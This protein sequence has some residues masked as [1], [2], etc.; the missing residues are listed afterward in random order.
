[1]IMRARRYAPTVRSAAVAIL[2]AAGAVVLVLALGRTRA[3]ADWFF[4][5]L[6][7]IWLW[8]LYFSAG[9]VALGHALVRR[10]TP[11]PARSTLE[12]LAL[13]FPLG[14]AGF[15]LGMYV[16]GFLRIFG[17]AFAVALPALMIATGWRDARRALAESP[18]P[19]PRPLSASAALISVFGLAALGVL[20]LG[21]MSPDAL[22]YDSVWNHLV[23]AQDYAREG[24]IV[25]F[26]G[27]W[28]KNLPH[29]GS[30][31]NAWAF[32]VPGLPLPALHWMMALHLEFTVTLWTIVGVAAGARWIA[33]REARG[34]WAMFFLFPGVFVY[35]SNMGAASDHYLAVFT[36]ATFLLASRSLERFDRRSC[37][38]WGLVT[39]AAFLT[40]VHALYIGAPLAFA[41][42]VRAAALT[43]RRAAGDLQA[44][45][46]LEIAQGLG[47]A[48][49][50]TVFVMSPHLVG[51]LV[52]FKNPVY[53]LLQNVF[54]ASTPAVK[55]AALQMDNLFVDWRWHPPHALGARAWAALKLV[56][57]FS[58]EPHYSFIENL[59]M[60]G[61]LFTLGLALLPLIPPRAGRLWWGSAV[62]LGA[63]FTWAF[64]FWVDRNLQIFMPLL[65]A[66]TAAVVIRA[67]ELGRL[68][69]VGLAL[70][71]TVQLAWAV[72]LY[73]S[74]RDRITGAVSLLS[75]AVRGGA[76]TH[77]RTYRQ[78]YIALGESLPKNAVVML[79]N[80]HGMLGIDR[81]VL[82]DWIGFEGIIDYRTFRTPR[83]LYDRLRA[84]GVTHV[85]FVPGQHP[86]A[87]KQEQA[88]F[89]TFATLYGTASRQFGGLVVFPLPATP[90]PVEPPYHA[91]TLGLG[92]YPDGLY[93]I[94]ALS[95]C[96]EMP[97]ALQH[98]PTPERVGAATMLI[99][100]ADVVVVGGGA[101]LDAATSERL[102]REFR[103][104]GSIGGLRVF[105]RSR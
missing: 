95:V 91:L 3:R 66:V 74:G 72:P 46:L 7:K 101:S 60:F 65:A 27:D 31:V 36:V 25:P 4:F 24:R 16:G 28:V 61:S 34:A 50:T 5:D 11:N 54:T 85:V 19:A 2:G 79:H 69:R 70:M 82:L 55:D 58:F 18:R 105:R 10:L 75:D 22:N 48:A 30:I 45:S 56:F 80:W 32:M 59:P 100:P 93:P 6:L 43:R 76:R 23:I 42:V 84:L 68:A 35:D 92:G 29:L 20:Y 104:V 9:C 21:V 1:M 26:P 52:F 97:P 44:P 96:E 83:D 87:S 49:A 67:A 37:V 12:T 13:S 33:E 40:K 103:Q 86:T 98:Y 17:P 38:A 57:T 77:L 88:I 81:R 41:S 64:T 63:L 71:L 73:F 15:V 90:P 62:G 89:D 39:G 8:A 47:L 99:D 94:E 51:H 53:P 14:L 78:E 102:S